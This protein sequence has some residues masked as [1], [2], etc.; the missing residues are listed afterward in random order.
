MCCSVAAVAVAVCVC[1]LTYSVWLGWSQATE[2]TLT[3]ILAAKPE[4][5]DGVVASMLHVLTK[6]AEKRLLSLACVSQ[7]LLGEYT[8]FAEPK[9]C[10]LCD[11][12]VYVCL[13]V[14]CCV[15]CLCLRVAGPL[16][17]TIVACFG[18]LLF[19]RYVRRSLVL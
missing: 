6:Q 1:L 3:A 2:R 8:K 7:K 5:R 16:L 17:F 14:V 18:R 10:F 13:Y 12:C 9:V 4:K 11:Q 15:L 19:A